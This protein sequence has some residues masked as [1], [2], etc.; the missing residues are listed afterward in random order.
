MRG[1]PAVLGPRTLIGCLGFEPGHLSA[2]E[3]ELQN[4]EIAVAPLW[5]SPE[6]PLQSWRLSLAHHRLLVVPLVNADHPQ[7]DDL[8]FHLWVGD[9]QPQGV[10]KGDLWWRSSLQSGSEQAGLAF[11]TGKKWQIGT[12]NP[13]LPAAL[14]EWQTWQALVQVGNPWKRRFW[15]ALFLFFCTVAC[16]WL[17]PM[18]VQEARKERQIISPIAIQAKISEATIEARDAGE[19]RRKFRT[20]AFQ[21][22]FAIP[23]DAWMVPWLDSTLKAKGWEEGYSASKDIQYSPAVSFQIRPQDISLMELDTTSWNA[24]QYYRQL[25]GDSLSY[26]TDFWWQGSPIQKRVHDGIDIAAP[27]GTRLFAPF[28]GKAWSWETP[29]GGRIAGISSGKMF[30]LFAHCDQILFFNGDSVQRGE[31]VAT[32]GMTGRTS[33]PHAHIGT[34]VLRSGDKESRPNF[35]LKDPV[36]WYQENRRVLDSTAKLV[37]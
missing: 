23:G 12:H 14:L 10:R 29:N 1:S 36:V 9:T 24:V 25:L 17:W 26:P 13:S 7:V 2:L 32:I 18:T 15:Q 19:L 5:D 27:I 34:G 6:I 11:W 37:R 3:A 21:I 20:A 28:D 30:V 16:L 4:P 31:A 8:H 33:G 22:G 35:V